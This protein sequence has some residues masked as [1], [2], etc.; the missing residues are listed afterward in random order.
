M[1]SVLDP[2]VIECSEFRAFFLAFSQS[3]TIPPTEDRGLWLRDCSLPRT[4]KALNTSLI[5]N[6]F[7]NSV[8]Y[9][10]MSGNLLSN[11]LDHLPN[12]LVINRIG[13]LR[14]DSIIYEKYTKV[15]QE[16][17]VNEIQK[18]DWSYLSLDCNNDSNVIFYSIYDKVIKVIDIYAP[19]EKISKKETKFNRKPWITT[20]LKISIRIK[21]ILYRKFLKSNSAYSHFKYKTYRNKLSI[22]LKVSKRNYYQNYLKSN[23]GNLKTIWSGI[24]K[25]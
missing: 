20:A 1:P 12:F 25:C 13:T 9:D 3:P 5:K 15:N 22:L 18:I 23:S 19:I 24:K 6:I 14:K 8:E 11:I 4:Q 7:S 16:K 2:I 21:N 10:T 17:I